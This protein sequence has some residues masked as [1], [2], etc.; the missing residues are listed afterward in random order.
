MPK[1]EIQRQLSGKVLQQA[2]AAGAD[3]VVVCCPLCHVNL[4]LKQAQIN[5]YCGTHYD[6]PILYLP[7]V[8]GL[9]FGLTPDDVMLNK[10]VVDPEP[11]VKKAIAEAVRIKAE[12][13]QKSADK[14]AKAAAKE[15]K[16]AGAAAGGGAAGAKEEET[17]EAVS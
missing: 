5:S 13:D 11:L 14:A 3:A 16:A 7:Q 6:V 1:L 8:L 12:E 9:A 10:N 15:A 17:A 2:L 4:D